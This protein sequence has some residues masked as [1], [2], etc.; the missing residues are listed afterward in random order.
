MT[1]TAPRERPVASPCVSVCALDEQDICTGCQRTVD[2][3]TRWGSMDN[4]QR[5]AVLTLC[6]ERAVAAGLM[7]GL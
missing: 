7:L 3:I 2:E 4:Q 1:D 5:R 6:H